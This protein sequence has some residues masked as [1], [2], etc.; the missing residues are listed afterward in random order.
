MTACA[1]DK[2]DKSDTT[3]APVA[4]TASESTTVETTFLSGSFSEKDLF[5]QYEGQGFGLLSD[6]SVL[7]AAMG[8]DYEEKAAPSCT[9]VGDDKN[10]KYPGL[11]IMTNPIDGKD[12]INEMIVTG[13]DFVTPRGIRIG[14]TREA[15]V[16][17]YGEGYDD[18]GTLTY[19]VSGVFEEY[20][21][22]RMFISI[23]DGKVDYI[24]YFS[25]IS[26][27]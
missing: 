25:G 24:S 15:V 22:D 11:E 17:A 12:L 10:F 1:K 14:D 21:S 19:V 18:Q 9:F 4:T 6:V 2:M 7:L 8:D 27:R 26:F 3:S 23:K 13:T 20:E 16:A 5:F